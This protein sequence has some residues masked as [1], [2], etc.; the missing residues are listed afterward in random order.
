MHFNQ[1]HALHSHTGSSCVLK[2]DTLTLVYLVLLLRKMYQ[3]KEKPPVLRDVDKMYPP[4]KCWRIP[5]T[6]DAE[7]GSGRL[8]GTAASWRYIIELLL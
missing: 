4:L 2:R 5:P 7:A 1:N 6:I 8:G 3:Q